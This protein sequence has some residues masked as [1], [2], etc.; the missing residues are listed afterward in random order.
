[1]VSNDNFG[2]LNKKTTTNIFDK[3]KLLLAPSGFIR[4]LRILGQT[5][6]IYRLIKYKV[7]AIKNYTV[8]FVFERA[9]RQDNFCD[10]SLHFLVKFLS[11]TLAQNKKGL[12]NRD[13]GST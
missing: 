3:W 10:I 6:A 1:M 5:S 9:F 7:Y 2:P 11:Q 4:P 8:G 12:I 13:R